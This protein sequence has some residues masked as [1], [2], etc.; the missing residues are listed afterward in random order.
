MSGHIR[1][2][3]NINKA[4]PSVGMDGVSILV[5]TLKIEQVVPSPIVSGWKY[6]AMY[7]DM[8]ESNDVEYGDELH[9]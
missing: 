4:L 2:I 5:L 7:N 8:V 9:Q 3:Y 1:T 6:H